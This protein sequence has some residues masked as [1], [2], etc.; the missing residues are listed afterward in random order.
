MNDPG[1]SSRLEDL[2]RELLAANSPPLG[3]MDCPTC[4]GTLHVQHSTFW[5][6][7]HQLL[8]L[9]MHCENCG[10]AL[11]IDVVAPEWAKKVT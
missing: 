5:R 9:N 6:D 8:G 3:I 1:Q 4:G 10:S 11:A 2:A 7:S